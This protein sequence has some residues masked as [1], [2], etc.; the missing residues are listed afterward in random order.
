L[1]YYLV[2]LRYSDMEL[3]E[4]GFKTDFIKRIKSIIRKNQF[5]RVQ[6]IIAKVSNRTINVDF[7]YNRD[8]GR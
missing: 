2:D 7:R 3:K 8:W 5:K 6:P 4:L 1:L